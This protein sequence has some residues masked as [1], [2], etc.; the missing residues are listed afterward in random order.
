MKTTFR[1]VLDFYNAAQEYLNQHAEITKLRYALQKSS[2]A[3][4]RVIQKHNE[5]VERINIEFAAEDKDGL[6]I[7]DG[8]GFRMKRDR[9]LER[10]SRLTKL[11]DDE[12]E[13]DIYKAASVPDGLEQIFHDAFEGWIIPESQEPVNDAKPNGSDR[14]TESV[15]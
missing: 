8:K 14:V 15:M 5:E 9:A 4:V 7:S 13:I 3:C 6:L 12:V 10:A 11:A 1:E 2:K